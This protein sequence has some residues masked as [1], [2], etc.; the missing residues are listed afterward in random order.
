[1][2]SNPSLDWHLLVSHTLTE[3]RYAFHHVRITEGADFPMH[4]HDR[5]Y[6]T[7]FVVEGK[8]IVT[9]NGNEH[10][11]SVG[12]VIYLPPGTSHEFRCDGG[13]FAY[14]AVVAPD[15]FGTD[16]PDFVFGV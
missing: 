8:G 6:A 16:E 9:L 1:M 12:D 15:K 7:L 3:E 13:P 4:R 10:K 2:A 5:T 11:L 14:V